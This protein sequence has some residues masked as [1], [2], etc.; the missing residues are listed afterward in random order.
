MISI[1]K[2]TELQFERERNQIGRY[3]VLET[4]SP[5]PLALARA[6]PRPPLPQQVR[7]EQRTCDT[8]ER[9]DEASERGSVSRWL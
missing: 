6:F 7:R 5:F 9:T 2:R 1:F 8:L 3:D 4:D